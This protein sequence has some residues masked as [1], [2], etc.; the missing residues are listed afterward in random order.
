MD[1]DFDN[2]LDG[3]CDTV[4]TFDFSSFTIPIDW[5]GQHMSPIE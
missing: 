3:L 2:D 1:S 4:Q 5:L